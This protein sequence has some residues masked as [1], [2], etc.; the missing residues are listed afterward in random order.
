VTHNPY[1]DNNK[2]ANRVA[3][4][5]V[6]TL[7]AFFN[8]LVL[9]RLHQNGETNVVGIH[10]SWFVPAIC[11]DAD[12]DYVVGP[13]LVASCID[14]A[15]CPLAGG[16]RDRVRLVRGRDARHALP[17]IRA[18]ASSRMVPARRGPRLADV[19]GGLNA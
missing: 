14:E 6:H 10:D 15:G 4:C 2:L 11:V 13:K 18:R 12:G 17:A 3:P 7:E 1:V 8:S 9:E 16:H 19:Y 5:V